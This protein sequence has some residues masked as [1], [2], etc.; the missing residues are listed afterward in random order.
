M[1]LCELAGPELKAEIRNCEG[2]LS[3]CQT[4]EQ[5]KSIFGPPSFEVEIEWEEQRPSG[6][7]E[8]FVA[9]CRFRLKHSELVVSER[10]DGSLRWGYSY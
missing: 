9:Q 4:M 10:A 6:E 2:L 8:A 7:R 3:G 1:K 5:V